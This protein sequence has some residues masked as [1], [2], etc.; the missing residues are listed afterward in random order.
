M[1]IPDRAEKVL[2]EIEAYVTGDKLDPYKIAA[3]SSE[4]IRGINGIGP[5]FL[6]KIAA[7]LEEEDLIGA[8]NWLDGEVISLDETHIIEEDEPDKIE[9][10]TAPEPS[11]TLEDL[12]EK[13][14]DIIGP[15]SLPV[16]IIEWVAFET[17]VKQQALDK[18]EE[19]ELTDRYEVSE[20]LRKAFSMVSD[21]KRKQILQELMNFNKYAAI[22]E[23][24]RPFYQVHWI[25][26][27]VY[28]MYMDAKGTKDTVTINVDSKIKRILDNL[29]GLGYTFDSREDF[30]PVR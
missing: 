21:Q 18:I 1:S 23:C 30:I 27:A 25:P 24:G 6:K 14:A 4:T 15:H 10:D 11:N 22:K 16:H 17:P 26:N 28:W 20:K 5:G 8:D 19:L 29:R 3:T 7:W 12:Q 9:E 2:L 13:L